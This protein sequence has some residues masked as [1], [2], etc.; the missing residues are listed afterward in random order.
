MNNIFKRLG[1]GRKVNV[2]AQR[3]L[4]DFVK[5][6]ANIEKAAYGSMEKRNDLIRRAELK[7]QTVH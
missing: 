3:E 4:V 2:D 7:K 5:S 6:K 1:L